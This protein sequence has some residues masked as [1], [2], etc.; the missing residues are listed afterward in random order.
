MHERCRNQNRADYKW[1]GGRGIKV[2]ERW[3]TLANF[4]ADMGDRPKGAQ[5][6]RIDNSKD[7]SPENCRWVSPA[8][9]SNNRRTNRHITINGI[10]KTLA[11]WI[12]DSGVKPST[13]HQRFYVYGWPIE[14]ALTTGVT[15]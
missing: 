2:C 12:A 7:Y 6:D 5:L 8:Q 10:T 9:N 15:R 14:K 11:E 1:Y 13:V 4:V 3:S